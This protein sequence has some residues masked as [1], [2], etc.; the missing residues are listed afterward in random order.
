L[1]FTNHL[2]YNQ[3]TTQSSS[4]I[5]PHTFQKKYSFH[6]SQQASVA[7]IPQM[8]KERPQILIGHIYLNQTHLILRDVDGSEVS[9][10]LD[11]CLDVYQFIK[12][13]LEEIEAQ[14]Q[15]NWQEFITSVDRPDQE[16]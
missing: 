9:L 7:I 15:A 10:T 14:R 3:G 5:N 1:V 6:R 11:D 4:Y 13:H 2:S 12:D 16:Q 8:R